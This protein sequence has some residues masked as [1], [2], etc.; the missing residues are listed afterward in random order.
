[1]N[2]CVLDMIGLTVAAVPMYAVTD[3][4]LYAVDKERWY[5]PI[6]DARAIMLAE[7]LVRVSEKYSIA[8][9]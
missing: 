8:L 4:P 2:S 7:I 6:E 9:S 3:V 1:M 5:H